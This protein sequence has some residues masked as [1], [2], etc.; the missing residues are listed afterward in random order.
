MVEDKDIIIR[1]DGKGQIYSIDY[2]EVKD[3]YSIPIVA[4]LEQHYP[5]IL[6]SMNEENFHI[7]ED[8]ECMM[9]K[10]IVHDD[11]VVGF[12]A[13][14]G[15][16]TDNF[17]ALTLQY[18]YVLPDYRSNNLLVKDII[19][20]VSF[21]RY[22]SIELPTHF[23]VDSL[24]KNN[25]AKI[26]DDRFVVSRVPFSVPITKFSDQE[27][28]HFKKVYNIPD[29]TGINRESSLYDLEYSAVVCPALDGS[30]RAYDKDDS[31]TNSVE[32]G[33]ISKVLEIDD[34]YFDASTK[35]DDDIIN[36]SKY[37]DKLISSINSNIN[38]IN[39]LLS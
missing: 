34:K 2:D 4:F 38:E 26:F 11:K 35:R 12:S 7:P 3:K 31:S 13:Y 17:K 39:E 1:S 19:D 23:V 16:D 22:V 15:A 37:F 28:E 10:E 36:T 8:E 30:N 25:I 5:Y 27:K 9:L 18:I 14:K 32:D 21:G 29:P 24:I 20:T 33:Y 6:D